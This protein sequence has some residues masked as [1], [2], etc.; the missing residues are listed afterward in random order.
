ML[1]LPAPRDYRDP[2]GPILSAEQ[3]IAHTTATLYR[4]ARRTGDPLAEWMTQANRGDLVV[5]IATLN[6]PGYDGQR[7][8]IIVQLGRDFTGQPDSLVLRTPAGVEIP[9]DEGTF[10]RVIDRPVS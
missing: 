5:E 3:V 6:D 1:S 4:L 9:W 2:E 10:V 7:L 8:G